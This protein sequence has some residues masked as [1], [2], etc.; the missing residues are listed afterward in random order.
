MKNKILFALIIF[1]FGTVFAKPSAS[2]NIFIDGIKNTVVI[3]ADSE[4]IG[5]GFLYKNYVITAA[6]CHEFSEI[7][8]YEDYYGR[9]DFL[10][11]RK[12]NFAKDV[13][14]Y[15]PVTIK[16]NSKFKLSSINC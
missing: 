4:K 5:T 13:A 3:K 14:V 11:L 12:I 8:S 7:M 1:I 6:H 16:F 15:R 2:N 9:E 10:E